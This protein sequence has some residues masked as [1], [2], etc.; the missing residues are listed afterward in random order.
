MVGLTNA[1]PKNSGIYTSYFFAK[2]MS[3]GFDK[4]LK[5]YLIR[6]EV[7]YKDM[8]S[9][10]CHKLF[11]ILKSPILYIIVKPFKCWYGLPKFSPYIS[12]GG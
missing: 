12:Y 9:V 5:L 8:L 1:C 10:T 11:N 6:M 7:D 3:H 4:L 2:M